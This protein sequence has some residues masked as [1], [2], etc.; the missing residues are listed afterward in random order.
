MKSKSHVMFLMLVACS[1]GPSVPLQPGAPWPKLRRDAAQTG[2]TSAR[3]AR[4][5]LYWAFPTG[6]G[7]FSSPVVGADGTIYVGSADRTFYALRRDGSVRWSVTTGEIIDSAGLLDDRGRVYFGSGDGKLRA[8]DAATGA[9]AWTFAADD[10]AHTGGVINWF[11]GNVALAPDGTLYVPN[12][13]FRIYALDR[14]HGT[15]RWDFQTPD[16][17]WSLPAVDGNGDLW[18]GNNNVVSFLGDNTFAL[19]HR[20]RPRWSASIPGTVAASPLVADGR[21][22]VGGFDG[23]VRA[24]DAASGSERWSFATRD[25]LYASPARL[26][27][28]KIVQAS[29]DGSVYALD[30]KS[31]AIVWQYD[32]LAPIRSSP[33]V[34]GEGNVYF[35]NGEGRLFSLDA[36]GARRWAIQLASGPRRDLNSSPALGRDAIY[37]GGESGEIFSVPFDLCDRGDPRC[38]VGAGSDLPTD[39]AQLY[40]TT[41]LGAIETSAP[42]TIDANQSLAF[43]LTV[44]KTGAT[45]LALIDSSSLSV[46]TDPPANVVVSVSGDRRWLSVTPQAPLPAGTLALAVRGQYLVDPARDGLR[47][48]G[49]SPGGTF[50]ARFAF[51]VADPGA[52]PSLQPG[53][54][55]ELSRLAAPLPT[56]LPSYNQI[57]FDS[58]HYLV[59]LVELDGTRGVAWVAG[60]RV[61][62]GASETTIDPT[63]RGL[64]PVE[65]A[66]DGALVTLR[67]TGGFRLEVMNL[68]LPLDTFR[69]DGRVDRG[70]GIVGLQAS[71]V[72]SAVPIYG[73]FLQRLG[74]CNPQTDTMEVF[75]AAQLSPAPPAAAPTGA[76]SVTF[77]A[78][79][80]A[81]T[82]TLAGSTLRASDHVLSLLLI[83]DAS[84]APIPLDYGLATTRTTNAD[85]TV[86]TVTLAID[87]ALPARVRAHLMVDVASAAHGT[88]QIH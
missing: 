2:A 22:I 67:S 25:H 76:G 27:D 13:N 70:G 12:D 37:L 71:T 68:A 79:P 56:V 32:T 4:G 65:V 75:G 5:G 84:G 39:G 51:T 24:Y 59:G 47:L 55:W 45:Q 52:L 74:F 87:R 8:L 83:D 35:G 33:A 38:V 69:V 40:F 77:S 63:T 6:N 18:F 42:T 66:L 54:V 53:A 72:C 30:P 46:T 48:S 23:Y 20:G 21:M 3:P 19:D 16:Q 80:T 17:T 64:F 81:I 34:D 29:A 43:T 31:G 60:A 57:G 73:P 26:P 36:R 88:L 7:V 85:G 1:A 61:A 28:G 58:L 11:E 82:A 14:D 9:P 10:P 62:E 50:E 41:N 15:E 86:A 49:G 44:R 78:T